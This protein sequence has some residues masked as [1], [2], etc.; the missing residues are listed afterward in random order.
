VVA[1]EEILHDHLLL[2]LA[3]VLELDLHRLT[4]SA[5]LGVEL[6]LRH[7]ALACTITTAM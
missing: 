5:S 3:R 4:Q 1:P 6:E 7:A 2:G